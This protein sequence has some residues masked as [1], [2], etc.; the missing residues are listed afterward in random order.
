MNTCQNI[1]GFYL[2]PINLK[3]KKHN[4]FSVKYRNKNSLALMSVWSTS[5]TR[6]TRFGIEAGTGDQRSSELPLHPHSHEHLF[7]TGGH[8]FYKR[9]H[10][11]QVR[12][13][14]F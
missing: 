5:T 4:F 12:S 6:N 11:Y 9:N 14:V 1:V 10:T 8:C 13:S 7:G 3:N 2:L